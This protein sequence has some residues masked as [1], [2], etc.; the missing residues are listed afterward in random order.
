MDYTFITDTIMDWAA[1]Y[2]LL[3]YYGFG[4]EACVGI[5]LDAVGAVGAG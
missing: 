3:L 1:T 4:V 2:Y 5:L